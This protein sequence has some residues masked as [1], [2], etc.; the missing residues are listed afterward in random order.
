MADVARLRD[1]RLIS[2]SIQAQVAPGGGRCRG[3]RLRGGSRS[4]DRSSGG[5]V[6][7]GDTA[8]GF[9]CGPVRPCSSEP[10]GRRFTAAYGAKGKRW[11]AA[12][13]ALSC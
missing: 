2:T 8:P 6:W 1:G 10:T 7:G 12:C 5:R 9:P 4:A 13:P 3:G 11:P